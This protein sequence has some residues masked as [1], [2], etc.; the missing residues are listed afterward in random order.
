MIKQCVTGESAAGA[1][2]N[3]G[4]LRSSYRYVTLGKS[5]AFADA[6]AATST[7]TPTY[8]ATAANASAPRRFLFAL[9]TLSC[10]SIT[11]DSGFSPYRPPLA[12]AASRECSK[13]EKGRDHE[14]IPSAG[15]GFSS[16]LESDLVLFSVL[17]Q[18]KFTIC[19][20]QRTLAV[21]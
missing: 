15:H 14:A 10:C 5:L 7:S 12:R 20:G 16:W 9:F 13:P 8:A 11:L 1:A 21:R 18:P 3:D 4:L 6:A 19:L 17:C 2:A